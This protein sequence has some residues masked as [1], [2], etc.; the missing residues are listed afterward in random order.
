MTFTCKLPGMCPPISSKP[1]FLNPENA[2]C[3]KSFTCSSALAN[4]MHLQHNVEA[5]TPSRDSHGKQK[6]DHQE[7]SC[8]TPTDPAGFS[9]FKVEPSTLCKLHLPAEPGS[10]SM[11]TDDTSDAATCNGGGS[12]KVARD[13]CSKQTRLPDFSKIPSLW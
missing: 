7:P 1:S 11:V 9:T 13:V 8:P 5:S 6:H 2:G 3:D 4:H 12:G 10:A